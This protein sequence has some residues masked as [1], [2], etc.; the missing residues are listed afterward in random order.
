MTDRGRERGRERPDPDRSPSDDPGGESGGGANRNDDPGVRNG[1]GRR[2]YRRLLSVLKWGVAL[3]AF[4]YVTRGV[5]W[6]ATAAELASVPPGVVVAILAITVLEFGSRFSMWYALLSGRIG[7]S[8]ATTA[9]IDLTIKFINHVIPSKAS[10]HSVA[11]LVLRHYTDSDWAEAVSIAGLNTGLYA[12]LYGVTALAGLV[13]FAPRLSRGWLLVILVSTGIYSAAGALILLAGRRLDVA[14][15][16]IGRLESLLARIPRIGDRL[17][18]VAATLPAFGADSAAVFRERSGH[19]GVLVGY[20]LGWAGTLMVVPGVRVWLLL[21]ALG[22]GFAPAVLLPVVLV[23]AYSVTVL[24]VTPGGVGVAEA[25]TT[26]VLASLGVDPGVAAVVVL[27]DRTL[28][29]YLPAALGWLP[30]ATID[31]PAVLASDS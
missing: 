9:R 14:G 11:P 1:S 5:D 21:D 24:P 10:G 27:V 29:V 18:G 19:P 12:T 8:L 20:A 30:A 4:W 16:L 22:G 3:G 23:M 25:S 17:A 2:H 31:L 26:A 6:V 15:A 7:V 28:G 13:L